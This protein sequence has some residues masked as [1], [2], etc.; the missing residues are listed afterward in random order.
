MNNSNI[1]FDDYQAAL[2][3]IKASLEAQIKKINQKYPKA[4]IGYLNDAVEP[5]ALTQDQNI[6]IISTI[7]FKTE[8][9]DKIKL[10]ALAYHQNP[11]FNRS[12]CII[13]HPSK[14]IMYWIMVL[15]TKNSPMWLQLKERDTCQTYNR[16]VYDQWVNCLNDGKQIDYLP[17]AYQQLIDQTSSPAV[18]Q[19][20]K[21]LLKQ[22]LNQ[23]A[24]HNNLVDHQAGLPLELKIE[25]VECNFTT[26]NTNN[27]TLN[28]QEPRYEISLYALNDWCFGSTNFPGLPKY[29]PD[30]EIEIENACDNDPQ[31]HK[32]L[33]S[34]L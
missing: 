29:D 3:P 10:M 4:L 12:D 24:A 16:I 20:Q 18:F 34:Y 5:N 2:K 26:I 22:R 11:A 32:Y 28:Y 15:S 17:A 33:E 31:L 30:R 21:A 8:Y 7:V 1:I 25:D 6:T 13:N 9:F 14:E 19:K 23:L 27:R